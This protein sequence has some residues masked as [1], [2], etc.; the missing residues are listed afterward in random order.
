MEECCKVLISILIV[1]RDDHAHEQYLYCNEPYIALWISIDN[2]CDQ[3]YGSQLLTFE[4]IVYFG[5]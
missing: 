2:F 3:H 1:E 5:V 4:N